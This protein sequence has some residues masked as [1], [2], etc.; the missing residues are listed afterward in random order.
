MTILSFLLGRD[1]LSSLG[2]SFCMKCFDKVRLHY[3]IEDIAIYY[4]DLW[5]GLT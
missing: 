4:K 5:Q 3:D 2:G 1:L